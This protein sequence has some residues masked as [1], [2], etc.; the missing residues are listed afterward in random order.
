ML[1]LC[2]IGILK[3]GLLLDNAILWSLSSVSIMMEPTTK[4]M[5]AY[6]ITLGY[7]EFKASE[8]DLYAKQ[9]QVDMFN[10]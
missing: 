6:E 8:G 4:V 1:V 2:G 10:V 7:V 9:A 3:C 5:A